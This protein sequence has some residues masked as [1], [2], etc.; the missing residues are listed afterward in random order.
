LSYRSCERCFKASV[1]IVAYETADALEFLTLSLTFNQRRKLHHVLSV[2]CRGPV[3]A[4]EL[5]SALVVRE[6]ARTS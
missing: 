6:K 1:E 4:K 3:A 5:P 2:R